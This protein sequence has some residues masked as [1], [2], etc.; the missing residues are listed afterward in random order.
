MPFWLGIVVAFLVLAVLANAVVFYV[1]YCLSPE[2]KWR[3]RIERH[4]ADAENRLRAG[5]REL[6]GAGVTLEKEKNTLPPRA[7]D[8]VLKSIS[9]MGLEAYPRNR[10]A[11]VNKLPTARLTT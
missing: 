7:L 6:E 10:P 3:A 9:V 4:M 2:K 8:T 11:T 5:R 1:L